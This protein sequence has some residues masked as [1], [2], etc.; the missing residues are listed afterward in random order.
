[1]LA[2]AR[3]FGCKPEQFTLSVLVLE[4]HDLPSAFDDAPVCN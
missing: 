4:V 2:K 3:R 1:M